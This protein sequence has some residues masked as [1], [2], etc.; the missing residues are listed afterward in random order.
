MDKLSEIRA[1]VP[2]VQSQV[3]LN[4]GTAGPLPEP[5]R[6]AMAESLAAQVSGGRIASEYYVKLSR[7]K[8]EI[9]ARHATMLGCEPDEIALTQNTTD[10]MNLVTLGVNWQPGDEAIT[11]NLEHAGALFPLFAARARF[12][13]TIKIADVL[14]RPEEAAAVIERLITPRTKLIAVSHVSFITGAVLPVK[15]IAEVAH[16][17][18]VLVLVDGAQSFGAIPVNVKELGVD[19][20]AVTSQKWLCGPE[21]A[22]ALYASRAAVSQVQITFAGYNTAQAY[23]MYA[24]LLPKGNAQ[25][26]EQGTLQPATLAGHL[27]ALRWLTDEVGADWAYS[28]I[29]SLA[30]AARALLAEVPG[31]T[32]LTPA[33][34]AGLVS[35]QVEANAD[36]VL[37]ALTGQKILIRTV[38]HPRSLRL[39]TGFY[40]TEEELE[41][42]AAALRPLARA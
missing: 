32:V 28:R 18:G 4:T 17:H 15:E 38:P 30:A 24:G 41:Q 21:G 13:I 40:N 3:Y 34:T 14:E 25:K 1:Q 31:V 39:S 19:F 42:L 23:D 27:A 10:G 16:R 5:V 11:T 37:K 26:F 2:A 33:E 29:R 22:G 36:A 9:R 6:A 7:L 35:F 20:Y 12:G 8:A